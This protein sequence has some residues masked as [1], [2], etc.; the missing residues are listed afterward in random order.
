MGLFWNSILHHIFSS[1]LLY[2][3]FLIAVTTQLETVEECDSTT[4]EIKESPEK[5]KSKL[6][7]SGYPIINLNPDKQ[8]INEKSGKTIN[9]HSSS[10]ANDKQMAKTKDTSEDKETECINETICKNSIDDQRI[11]THE[12]HAEV[13]IMSD[14]DSSSSEEF[15]VVEDAVNRKDAIISKDD[16]D[17]LFSD[18]FEDKKDI[19]KLEEIL[20]KGKIISEENEVQDDI[21][22]GHESDSIPKVAVISEKTLT[23]EETETKYSNHMEESTVQKE[24]PKETDNEIESSKEVVGTEKV[25]TPNVL[26]ITSNSTKMLKEPEKQ[27][28]SSTKLSI[29]ELQEMKDNLQREKID[30][31]V[32]KSSKERLATNISDQMYQEAQVSQ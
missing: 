11:G 16:D 14:T 9:V 6:S 23:P 5:I 17:D 28:E 1:N 20:V 7:S 25:S 21:V 24:Q 31:L 2:L 18:I 29:L 15:I 8:E 4:S 3:Q 12:E 26:E 30:L 13:E 22:E 19:E 10:I 27:N 32:E